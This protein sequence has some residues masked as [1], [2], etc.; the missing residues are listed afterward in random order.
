M[1][2]FSRRRCLHTRKTGA[3]CAEHIERA[4]LRAEEMVSIADE[5]N[6]IRRESA[7]GLITVMRFELGQ[8]THQ[9]IDV[10]GVSRVDD[11][12]IKSRDWRALKHRCDAADDDEIDA[13]AH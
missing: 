11:V 9:A 12:E 8:R 1:R 5:Q 3:Y 13:V 6:R 2:Q 4:E 7:I 10:V